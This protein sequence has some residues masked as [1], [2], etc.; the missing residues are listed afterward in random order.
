MGHCRYRRLDVAGEGCWGCE[1][2]GEGGEGRGEREVDVTCSDECCLA[3][4]SG[5][6]RPLHRVT[7]VARSG[8]DLTRPPSI[9]PL[10]NGT[11]RV[12]AAVPLLRRGEV[13]GIFWATVGD[14][15]TTTTTPAQ[16]KVTTNVLTR[17]TMTMATSTNEEKGCE[18]SKGAGRRRRARQR[19]QSS[20]AG[21]DALARQLSIRCVDV[22]R[23]HRLG[24]RRRRQ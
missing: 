24:R 20:R 12:G 9:R 22:Y 6:P 19:V 17:T 1:R 8:V 2:A 16:H 10:F 14:L 3:M 21:G 11:R 4:S 5:R 18:R 23:R 7:W 13:D 15:E